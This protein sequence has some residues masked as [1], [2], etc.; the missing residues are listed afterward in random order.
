MLRFVDVHRRF[1]GRRQ[2][3][4]DS[5]LRARRLAGVTFVMGPSGAGKSVFAQLAAGLL[6]SRLGRP[7]SSS[8]SGVEALSE[9]DRRRGHAAAARVPC[10]GPCPARLAEP[11]RHE[12]VA[13]ALRHVTRD[14]RQVARRTPLQRQAS[15]ERAWASATSVDRMPR[16][17]SGRGCASAAS[18]ARALACEP[19]ALCYE[20]ANHRARPARGPAGRRPLSRAAT[21]R[22][23]TGSAGG[24]ARPRVGAPHRPSGCWCCTR[25]RIDFDGTVEALFASAQPA[26][27]APSSTP[28][29]RPARFCCANA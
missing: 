8:A 20:R 1:G 13:L 26:E 17:T 18:V 5:E 3:S 12:N 4:T 10:P 2:S 28:D 25:G 22:A 24:L 19:Q 15:L 9:S 14:A 16:T 6:L 11:R 29:K 27:C 7:S 23:G 21:R